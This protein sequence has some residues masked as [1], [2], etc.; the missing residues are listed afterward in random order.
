MSDKDLDKALK[1]TLKVE[2]VDYGALERLNLHHK[3]GPPDA[4]GGQRGS[5]EHV[6]FQTSRFNLDDKYN[7]QGRF[8][9][10]VDE[11]PVHCRDG[12]RLSND[13]CHLLKLSLYP[14]SPRED[15]VNTCQLNLNN[16]PNEAVI[17]LWRSR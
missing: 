10:D 13:E 15:S 4:H 8:A 14:E 1:S 7:M 5:F 9:F 11:L 16:F 2:D 17:N 3:T 12:E 6:P